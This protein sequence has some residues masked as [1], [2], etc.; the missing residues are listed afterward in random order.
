MWTN[1]EGKEIKSIFKK[2][3]KINLSDDAQS[4]LDIILLTNSYF[5]KKNISSEEFLKLQSNYLIKKGDLKLIKTFLIKNKNAP[6]DS[7]LITYYVNSYL[8][9]LDLKNACEIFEEINLTFDDYLNKFKIYCLLNNEQ[10]EQAQL[11][12]DLVKETGF[13]DIFFE[14]KFN[15]LMGYEDNKENII[16]EENILNFHLSHRTIDQFSYKPTEKTSKEI[17]KY[18]SSSNLLEKVDTIDLE[19]IKKIKILEEATHNRNYSEKELFNLYKRFQFNFNELLT[20]KE[21]Y[22]LMPSFKGRALIYQRLLLTLEQEAILDLSSLL[23]ESFK[24]DEISNAF[25]IELANI[26]KKIDKENIPA[27]YSTFYESNI[28]EENFKN[29]KIKFNNKFIHQ[30][31]LLNYFLNKTDM[32]KT[33]KDTNELLKKIKKDKKYF[34]STKDIILLE[35]LKSDGIKIS[36]NYEKLYEANPDIPP[37]IQLKINNYE[38]AMALLRIAQIIGEDNIED[39]GSETLNFIINVLNELNM[40]RLRN[41]I[42]IKVLPLK[43]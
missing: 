20:A 27:N 30:S 25:N 3:N 37:D 32:T 4:F 38:T 29:K 23:K 34:F 16:S 18:L 15:I 5:P 1:S 8:S 42:L 31:K 2:I 11:L 24:G 10:N 12:F 33:E 6:I 22:K 26:L 21:T 43:V 13:D 39:L 14:N 17:W 41:E 36:K 9:N 40:D 35:A 28:E 7:N 19:D